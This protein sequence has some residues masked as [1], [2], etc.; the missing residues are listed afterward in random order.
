MKI[1]LDLHDFSITNNRLDLLL[2]LKDHFP[3][4]K[5]SLFMV[6]IEKKRSWGQTLIREHNLNEIRKNL[7]WM[8]IIPHGIE[9]EDTREIER[10]TKYDFKNKVIP[11]I[12][13]AFDGIP[14]EKGFC[15]PR[16]QWNK[17]VV[18]A[19][20][21]LGWWGAVHRDKDMPTPKRF[22]KYTHSLN[23]PFWKQ[24]FAKV[25]GHV[26]GTKND[27]GLCMDNL[28]KLPKDTQFY[29]ITNF[30]EQ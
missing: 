6:P 14:F 19:L 15:A 12:T 4:F 11:L 26:Y 10:L 8:Q 13:K 2:K 7:D 30:I 17:E 28:L 9:H 3:D 5:V 20:D 23:E 29:F 16:W 21:E 22:Y 18:E 1:A 27:L 24:D 25:H